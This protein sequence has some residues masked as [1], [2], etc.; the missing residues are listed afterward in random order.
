MREDFRLKLIKETIELPS[1][2]YCITLIR[3]YLET[4]GKLSVHTSYDP[5]SPEMSTQNSTAF[6]EP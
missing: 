4:T 2:P 3:Q 1:R 5:E 6:G